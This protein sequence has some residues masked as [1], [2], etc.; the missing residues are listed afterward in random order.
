M[1]LKHRL[2]RAQPNDVP[3]LVALMVEFYREADYHLNPQLAAQ[4]FEQ[5][6]AHDAMG[7]VWLADVDGDLA[8]YVVLTLGYS[9]E[10][11]GRDAFVDD[12]FVR[13]AHR[14]AGVGKALLAELRRECEAL[15]VRAVHL[16]V[17]R[18][19][20]P[21]HALYAAQGFQDNDRQLLT[22]RLSDPIHAA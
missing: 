12:L 7:R 15:G 22:L 2:R 13:P 4:A 17:E 16:E 18:Q 19:N 14:G 9:M 5:L 3:Q 20:T 6:L 1:A 10:Y 11:G 21:A 8:G